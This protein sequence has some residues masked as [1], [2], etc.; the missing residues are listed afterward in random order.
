MSKS[1]SKS[2]SVNG[3]DYINGKEYKLVGSGKYQVIEGGYPIEKSWNLFS[4]IEDAQEACRRTIDALT[5]SELKDAGYTCDNV[6]DDLLEEI[7]E[8][9]CEQ[10]SV[11]EIYTYFVR[12]YD[13]TKKDDDCGWNID[14]EFDPH[15]EYIMAGLSDSERAFVNSEVKKLEKD[16]NNGNFSM[17]GYSLRSKDPIKTAIVKKLISMI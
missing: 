11:S 12:P 8:E 7:F 17:K 3:F 2:K 5:M 10:V 4:G 6:P 14:K 9:W 1:K 13:G 16:I 15:D